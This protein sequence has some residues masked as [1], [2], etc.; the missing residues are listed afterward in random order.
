MLL[1][2]VAAC[3]VKLASGKN[4]TDAAVA[5]KQAATHF[6]ESAQSRNVAKTKT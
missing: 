2:P 6:T 5:L 4:P 3:V 1:N